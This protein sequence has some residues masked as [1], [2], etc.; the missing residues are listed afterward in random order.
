MGTPN[1]A[2]LALDLLSTL[3]SLYEGGHGAAVRQIMELPLVQCPEVLMLG[4]AS[5]RRCPPFYQYMPSCKW[6]R[7]Q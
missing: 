5:S 6:F 4:L 7:Q 1:Q 3:A 2:W